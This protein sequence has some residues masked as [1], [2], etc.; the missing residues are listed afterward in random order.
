MGKFDDKP[1][2]ADSSGKPYLVHA[3]RHLDEDRAWGA[4]L[5]LAVGDAF[6]TTLEFQRMPPAPF[7]PLLRGP[8]NKMIG[9]GPF[10]LA[11]GQVTDDTQMA[12]AL[13]RVLMERGGF[14]PSP[15]A[16]EYVAWAEHAFDIGNQ[17]AKALARIGEGE[18]AST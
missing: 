10:G 5:G 9:G 17:I 1:I 15:V 3:S 13:A 12:A 4:L 18:N 7:A 11:P 6:G 8:H 16:A 14:R 2:G